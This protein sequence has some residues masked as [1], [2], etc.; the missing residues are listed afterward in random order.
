MDCPR[1][2]DEVAAEDRTWLMDLFLEERDQEDPRE[3]RDQLIRDIRYKREC[4]RLNELSRLV[5]AGRANDNLKKEYRALLK[6]VKGSSAKL[7]PQ[8]F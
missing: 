2:C 7:V 1:I 8:E 5:S 4:R 3:R 6:R